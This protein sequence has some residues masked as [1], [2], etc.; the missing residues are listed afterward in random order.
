[1]V[2][3]NGSSWGPSITDFARSQGHFRPDDETSSFL[4][5]LRGL[6]LGVWWTMSVGHYKK[7][8]IHVNKSPLCSGRIIFVLLLNLFNG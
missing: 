4:P 3:L 2:K 6:R 1:M 8:K 7:N 5:P